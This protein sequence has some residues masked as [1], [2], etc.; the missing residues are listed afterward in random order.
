MATRSVKQQSIPYS[1]NTADRM[2]AFVSSMRP[3]QGIAGLGSEPRYHEG[4]SLI[5]RMALSASGEG[6]PALRLTSRQ[7]A[8]VLYFVRS[9]EPMRPANWWKDP[10]AGP[11]HL[12]GYVMVLETIEEAL[13]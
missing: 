10:I 3:M 4:R 5:E 1:D 2:R 12:V 9:S 13:S 7:C 6:M 8:D 11:S